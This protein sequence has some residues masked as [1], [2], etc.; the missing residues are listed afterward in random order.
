MAS[1]GNQVSLKILTCG[2]VNG[3]IAKF[4]KKISSINKKNGPFE[5][6]LC[7]GDFF[8]TSDDSKKEWELCQKG[9]LS[10][11]V[12]IYILGPSKSELREF[13]SSNSAEA[14]DELS[15]N[16]ICLGRKGMLKTMSGLQIAYMSMSSNKDELSD[17]AALKKLVDNDDNFIGVDI[18]ITSSWPKDVTKYMKTEIKETNSSGAVSR[19]ASFTKPRYHF[20]SDHKSFFE[21]LPYRN[22]QVLK[23]DQQHISRFISLAPFGNKDGEKAIY[24]LSIKP[25]EKM[26]R[27]ELIKQPT[28]ATEFPYRAVNASTPNQQQEEKQ[29]NFFF[30]ASKRPHGADGDQREKKIPKG[31]PKFT[32]PCWFCLGSKEVE[33]HLV[34]SVGN[35]C[36]V[37]LPKGALNKDHCLICPISHH[38]STVVL[39]DDTKLEMEKYKRSLGRMF[40]SENKSMVVYERN[41]YTQHLQLQVTGVP[42][43]VSADVKDSFLDIAEANGMEMTEVPDGKD[44]GEMVSVTTPFF[45][46]EFDGGERILHKVKG[47]MPVQFAREVLAS[48]SVL[49]LPDRTNWKDCQVDKEEE[50]ALTKAFRK[51]FTPYDFNFT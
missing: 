38:N 24:A 51:R 11:D 30:Q 33:K 29:D 16:V 15:N 10:V 39:D 37:A 9:K 45:A 46:A 3:R 25:L 2:S 7:C 42:S 1:T 47:R 18:L 40:R 14:G 32:G 5:L 36:Y 50:I 41:F 13:Y 6:V 22:H 27:E 49:N 23:E 35:L 28:D 12:P 26:S 8:D 21:R 4:F 17:V 34:V 48:P 20:S 31:A 19:L 44:I 43:A